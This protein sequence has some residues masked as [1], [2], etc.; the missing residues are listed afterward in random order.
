MRSAQRSV[1]FPLLARRPCPL[2]STRSSLQLARAP[3]LLPWPLRTCP[4]S[5]LL[6]RTSFLL[7]RLPSSLFPWRAS[8]C[9]RPPTPPVIFGSPSVPV[10]ARRSELGP[11]V[12]SPLAFSGAPCSPLSLSSAWSPSPSCAPLLGYG[13]R[14]PCC[15]NPRSCSGSS[16]PPPHHFSP[17]APGSPLPF[18]PALCS[19][20]QSLRCSVPGHVCVVVFFRGNAHFAVVLRSLLGSAWVLVVGQTHPCFLY[21][22]VV[23]RSPHLDLCPH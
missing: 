8:F 3:S 15:P 18:L 23:V 13:P 6:A 22:V 16:A 17:M 12:S 9:A 10:P 7:A 5:L 21:L 20:L 2:A 4:C 19:S 1:P 14:T 11:A